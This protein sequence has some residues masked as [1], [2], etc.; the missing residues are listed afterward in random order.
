[1]KLIIHPDKP[2]LRDA[3]VAAAETARPLKEPGSEDASLFMKPRLSQSNFNES[4]DITFRKFG[5]TLQMTIPIR[6]NL[7]FPKTP[8]KHNST[9]TCQKNRPGPAQTRRLT[10]LCRRE[11]EEYIKSMVSGGWVL[12]RVKCVYV[13]TSSLHR[14]F[15]GHRR[16]Q[17]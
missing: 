6:R 4:K 17:V 14:V 15:T 9:P 13:M 11:P 2:G 10:P 5:E 3:V 12:M 1:M 16:Q 8:L 7:T